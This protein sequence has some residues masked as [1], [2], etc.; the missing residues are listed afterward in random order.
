MS[1]KFKL[2]EETLRKKSISFNEISTFTK[3]DSDYILSL[4]DANSIPTSL[5][6]HY[7]ETNRLY[8][9]LTKGSTKEEIRRIIELHLKYKDEIA[10]YIPN[11]EYLTLARYVEELKNQK[12][13]SSRDSTEAKEL[14]KQAGQILV[15]LTQQKIEQNDIM[16]ECS[17]FIRSVLDAVSQ[18]KD[19]SQIL[20]KM[21]DLDGNKMNHSMGVALLATGLARGLPEVTEYTLNGVALCGLLHDIGYFRLPP[22]II[23]KLENNQLLNAEE[24]K[25]YQVHPHLGVEIIEGLRDRGTKI[26]CEVAVVCL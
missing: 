22:E 17:K 24:Y 5:W 4:K 13:A 1:V 10:L 23:Y 16:A 8:Q 6:F 3:L 20:L 7:K 26:S 12:W 9:Y 15:A 19:L 2:S 14:K 21:V 11:S 18:S 25:V